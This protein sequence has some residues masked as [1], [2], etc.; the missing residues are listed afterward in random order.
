MKKS[1]YAAVAVLLGVNISYP[2][3]SAL[4]LLRVSVP[5]SVLTGVP[6]RAIFGKD[7][8]QELF[9]IPDRW[10]EAGRSI[11]GKV[12]ADHITDHGSYW[13]LHGEPLSHK[14]CPGNRF[15]DE[16]TVPSCTGFLVK[17]DLLVTAAH[18]IK[19]QDDCDGFYWVFEYALSGP[20]DKNYTKAAADRVYRCKRI[21]AKNY[22]NFGDVDYAILQ[23]NRTVEGRKPLRL[24][25]DAQVSPGLDLVN[26]GNSNGLPLKFKDSAKIIN[27]KTTGQA[28]ES[29]LD[30]FGG[31]SGSPVF[32]AGTGEVIGITSSANSDHY[33]DG[34]NN[35]RQLKVCNPG[36]KCYLAVASGIWNLK[37][38]PVLGAD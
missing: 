14:E 26:I 21:V 37:S 9:S 11:A 24:G 18:C 4:D 16:I 10:K 28:F 13:E 12:S 8:R 29:D 19:S 6:S 2:G 35:C 23:L 32:D 5:P 27:I 3:E 33:H 31:D 1:L 30:T 22:Q 38:E 25:L 17:P 15:A 36:D 7:D 20:G 34:V